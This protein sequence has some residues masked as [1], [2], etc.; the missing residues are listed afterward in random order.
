MK[1]LIKGIEEII[2]KE[3]PDGGFVSIEVSKLTTKM[4]DLH[5]EE[6]LAE[7]EADMPVGFRQMPLIAVI[8]YNIAHSNSMGWKQHEKVLKEGGFLE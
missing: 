8:K 6:Q 2:L 5:P 7:M 1:K 4:K 3:Y